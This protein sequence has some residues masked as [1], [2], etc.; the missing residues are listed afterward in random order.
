MREE[1]RHA[2]DPVNADTRVPVHASDDAGST[3]RRF[4]AS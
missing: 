4:I 3:V 2:V 1:L